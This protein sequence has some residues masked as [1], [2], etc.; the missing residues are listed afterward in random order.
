MLT[1][2]KAG[3]SLARVSWVVS[4]LGNSSLATTTAALRG[5]ATDT[6]TTCHTGG[7]KGIICL[8]YQLVS[9]MSVSR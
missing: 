3:L 7:Y 8:S 9:E 6:G 2:T 4:G 5:T 1:L